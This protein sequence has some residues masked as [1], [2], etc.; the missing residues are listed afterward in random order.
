MGC[1]NNSSKKAE[2]LWDDYSGEFNKKLVYECNGDW[3]KLDPDEQEIA[4]L[5]KLVADTYN[6]GFEQFFTN[7]GYE[8][9]WYAMRGIQRMGDRELLELLHGTYLN[10]FDKFREDER[11]TYYSDIFDYLTEE[12]EDILRETNIAFWE[13][14]G[15]RLCKEAYEFYHD[16]LK[17][18]V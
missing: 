12:D 14:H 10:V 8:C 6:G 4:A 5:W 16:N 15:D 11:L 7:W 18:S 17:K 13:E 2:D 9:Y 3:K 1:E